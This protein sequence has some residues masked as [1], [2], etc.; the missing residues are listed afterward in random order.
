MVQ[1]LYNNHVIIVGN[2]LESSTSFATSSCQFSLLKF[3]YF[4]FGAMLFRIHHAVTV[5]SVSSATAP[6]TPPS[7]GITAFASRYSIYPI[8]YFALPQ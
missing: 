6:H 1:Y 4:G 3:G 8:K 7:I 2:Y 5:T